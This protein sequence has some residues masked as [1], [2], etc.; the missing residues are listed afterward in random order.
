MIGLTSVLII[1][2]LMTVLAQGVIQ[3][4]HISE[5][6]NPS[7]SHVLAHIVGPWGAVFVNIGLII[8]VLG[9][10]LGWT[11]LAGELP[12]VV[13]KNNLFPKWFAKENR[14]G[15]PINSLLI[16]NILVQLFFNQYVIY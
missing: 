11:L 9:A 1:Y 8:S 4:N 2:F 6:G 15:A 13:A 7:M 3:Q 5:L 12:Y 16:T 10:W 14:N